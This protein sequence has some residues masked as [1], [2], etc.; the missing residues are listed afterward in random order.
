[1]TTFPNV[2]CMCFLMNYIH[3]LIKLQ[4]FRTGCVSRN[5]FNV[6]GTVLIEEILQIP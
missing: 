1:M 5:K 3:V 2:H 6:S 4:N